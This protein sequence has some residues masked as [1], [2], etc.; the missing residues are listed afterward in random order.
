MKQFRLQCRKLESEVL[1]L[2]RELNKARLVRD[3]LKKATAYFAWE[4]LKSKR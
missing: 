3:V 4:S 1:R 2:R